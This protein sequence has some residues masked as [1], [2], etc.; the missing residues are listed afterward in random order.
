M[1]GL[2]QALIR[3]L[4]R[5]TSTTAASVAAPK[6]LTSDVSSGSYV[7]RT[8]LCMRNDQ[9][10]PGATTAA[11]PHAP[12]E[13]VLLRRRQRRRHG[14]VEALQM[15]RGQGL[16][17]N[18]LS[19]CFTRLTSSVSMARISGESS[20]CICGRTRRTGRVSLAAFRKWAGRTRARC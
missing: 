17:A 18:N 3:P 16:A 20:F 19:A 10:S 2:K 12:H 13:H 11:M 1:S 6:A 9:R 5:H 7:S 15:G 4:A 8:S 14:D